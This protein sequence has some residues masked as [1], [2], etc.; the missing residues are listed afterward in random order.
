MSI[1]QYLT[2]FALGVNSQG[3]LSAAKG[4]TGNTT[5][6]GTTTPTITAI[7]YPGDDT[8]ADPAGG[9][10]ITLTGTNF[11]TGAKVIVNGSQPS[12]VSVVST[13]QITFTCP[14]LATGSYIIYVVNADGTTAIAAPGLQVSGLPTWTTSAGTLGT[15]NANSAVSYTVAATGDA[16]ITYSVYSGSL[17][18]GLTLNSTTGTIS[19]TTPTPST[20]T[21][22]NFTIRSTD[23]QK[24][25]TDRAFSITVNPPTPAGQ[26]AFITVGTTSWTVPAGVN[27]ISAVCIGAGA[28]SSSGGGG[29]GLRWINDLPVTPGETLTVVVGKSNTVS[30]A[31]DSSIKRGTN[32]LV[33]G[34]G[35]GLSGSYNRLGGR[36][37]T[38]G[39]GP[40]GGTIG[41]GNG[42][43]SDSTLTYGSPGSVGDF[44]GGGGGGAGGYSGAGGSGAGSGQTAAAGTGGGG[45]GGGRSTSAPNPSGG[46]GGGVGLYGEGT[47]GAAGSNAYSAGG[48]G[49]GSG[50]TS[51]AAGNYSLTTGTYSLGGTYGGGGGGGT[52]YGYGQQGAVRIIWG[53]G[54]AFP[55]TLT[56]DQ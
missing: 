35:A 51:G 47:S 21:T 33:Y 55:S 41:G 36:G 37:S 49:G 32:V 12:A 27:T 44:V 52:Y 56:T 16:P 11:A 1:A 14:A 13:T 8:A 48:G 43:H 29:G 2:K 20:A 34:G 3:V 23:A 31:E 26:Q 53:T 15:A 24:Q 6:G 39:A 50:G 42:G 45:G 28:S 18:S 38:V 25:D 9:Q 19:G 30:L 4:G 5:G 7:T 17:P 46:G 22:Y 54:R 10:T 40:Y